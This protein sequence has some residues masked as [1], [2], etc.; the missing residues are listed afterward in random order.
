MAGLVVNSGKRIFVGV[1]DQLSS[2]CSGE[3][4]FAGVGDQISF[5]CSGERVFAGAD[6]TNSG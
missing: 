6:T 1:D 3:P 2:A 5:V 4:G